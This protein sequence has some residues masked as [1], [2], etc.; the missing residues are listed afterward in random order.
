V[1]TLQRA[2]GVPVFIENDVNLAAVAERRV[3][4]AQDISDFFLFWAGDGIGGALLLDDRLRRGATGGAGEIAFLQPPGAD[5][6][7]RPHRSGSGALELWAG[8][9]ALADLAHECGLQ[10]RGAVALVTAAVAAGPD[11]QSFLDELAQRYAHGISSVIAVLDPGAIVLAG[12]VIDAGG[13]PLRARV[14][15][16]LDILAVTSPRLL[17][18]TVG[19]NPVLVGAMCTALDHARATVFGAA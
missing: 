19:G 10:G 8:G 15:H 4:A 12:P 17:R 16:H 3:G 1:R 11:G 18:G 2:T 13:E 7:H 9:T 14:E 6:V 5:T